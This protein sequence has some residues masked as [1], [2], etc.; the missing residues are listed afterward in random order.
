MK[1]NHPAR[2]RSLVE[3]R[4]C[5]SKLAMP[6]AFVGQNGAE[7]RESTKIAVASCPKVKKTAKRH[8]KQRKGGKKK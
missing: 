2:L 4:E 3:G 1:R 5:K 7:I 6:T 8:K